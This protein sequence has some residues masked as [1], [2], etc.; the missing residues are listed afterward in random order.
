M[1][2][3]L[4][5]MYNLMELFLQRSAYDPCAPGAGFTHRMQMYGMHVKHYSEVYFGGTLT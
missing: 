1:V 4:L 3:G 5:E 2:G